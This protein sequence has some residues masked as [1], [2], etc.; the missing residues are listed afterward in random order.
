M[1]FV[2]IFAQFHWKVVDMAFSPFCKL[3][4]SDCKFNKVVDA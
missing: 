2:A 4:K 3:I 1:E